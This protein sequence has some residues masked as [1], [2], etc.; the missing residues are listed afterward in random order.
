MEQSFF[1]NKGPLTL[2]QVIDL[3]G[4]SVPE[5]SDLD[6]LIRNIAPLETAGPEDIVYMDNPAY[7]NQLAATK[8]GYCFVSSR[9]AGKV[10]KTT[11]ILQTKQPY[12]AF[13]AIIAS[14]FPS[15]M[16]PEPVFQRNGISPYA[17]VHETAQLGRNVILDPGV[18][19]GE[20]V[21]IGDDTIIGAHTTI[22]A[23]SRIGSHCSISSQVSITHSII[24]N[25]VIIHSGC[26]I[27]QDGFGFAM[28]P[29]GHRKVPQIGKVLIDDNVEIGANTTIDRGASKDTIIGEGTKIDNLVQIGHNVKIGKHCVI[30]SCVGIAGSTVLE[31]FVVLGGGAGLAGHLKLGAGS[32]LAAFS[33]LNQ[34]IP[35]GEQWG[36]YP[37][38]TLRSW[39]REIAFLKQQVTRSSKT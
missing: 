3:T 23:H 8:A 29:Q 9:F 27:G 17:H 38:K 15:A 25:H 31:D 32:Q 22:G 10:P 28:G 14:L 33:G 12:H 30:V 1:D 2:K 5:N 4:C 34:D 35:A 19:I 13:A 21:V 7:I 36:G 16:K 6:K 11:L 20:Q 24:G 18:V 39:A 37:A 26:R